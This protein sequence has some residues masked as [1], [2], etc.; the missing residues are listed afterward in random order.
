MQDTISHTVC[1]MFQVPLWLRV[2]EQTVPPTHSM[3]MLPSSSSSAKSAQVCI[4]YK[5]CTCYIM[6]NL[7]KT[8]Y[9][10]CHNPPLPET[11]PT[12]GC[13]HAAWYGSCQL[14]CRDKSWPRSWCQQQLL[15]LLQQ[16]S[17]HAVAGRL[18][19]CPMLLTAVLM[20]AGL[21]VLL[22]QA[23]GPQSQWLHL[24]RCCAD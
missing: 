3:H 12:A 14:S 13:I 7:Y 20:T 5:P 21:Q 24:H 4:L 9:Q 18:H 1:W 2:P 19:V 22:V 10:T 17:S 6:H 15:L 23:T 16:T 8:N 11:V